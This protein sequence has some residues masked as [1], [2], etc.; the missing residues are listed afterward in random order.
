MDAGPTEGFGGTP[1]L[2][3]GDGVAEDLGYIVLVSRSEVRINRDSSG[4]PYLTVR[5]E[6]IGFVTDGLLRKHLPRMFSL[7]VP[8]ASHWRG[9]SRRLHGAAGPLVG[10]L[11]A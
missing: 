7:I 8:L 10:R 3:P 1:G 5:G 4:H 9:R 6:I 11:G 2:L